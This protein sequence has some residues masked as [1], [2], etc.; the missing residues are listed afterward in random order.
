MQ[1]SGVDLDDFYGLTADELAADP[2]D[3]M[4]EPLLERCVE[5]GVSCEGRVLHLVDDDWYCGEHRPRSRPCRTCGQ[6]LL[7]GQRHICGECIEE[8]E[9]VVKGPVIEEV[10][11]GV[12]RRYR[13]MREAA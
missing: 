8:V 3:D 4:I 2:W 10:P 1:L 13:D 5:C 6:S 12:R 9:Q 7:A 11:V